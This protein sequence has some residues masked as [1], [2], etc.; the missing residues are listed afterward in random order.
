MATEHKGPGPD[1]EQ[2]RQESG[3]PG[4][5]RGRTDRPGHTGVYPLSDDAGASDAAPLRDEASWGQGERGAAGY[6]DSGRSGP[7]VMPEEPPSTTPQQG[8]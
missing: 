8:K 5:G 1:D 4:G 6:E 2:A 3:M 7:L